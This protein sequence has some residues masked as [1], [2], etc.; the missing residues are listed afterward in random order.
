MI[1]QRRLISALGATACLAAAALGTPA[2]AATTAWAPV[3]ASGPTNLPPLQSEIQ[4]LGVDADGGAFK[5][6]FYA[7][8]GRG[9]V[10]AG[11]KTVF[12][13]T[14]TSGNFAVG[15]P[16]AGQGIAAGTTIA[17]V[18]AG[19][20]T[21][22]AN[23]TASSPGSVDLSAG[24]AEA[25]PTIP[26]NAPAATVEAVLDGLPLIAAGGGSVSVLGGPGDENST[27]PY[28]IDFD[29]G[30]L[31]N[32]NVAQLGADSSALEGSNK[33]AFVATTVPGGAGTTDVYVYVQ[34]VGSAES[35]GTTTVAIALP[36]GIVATAT[37]SGEGSWSCGPSGPGQFSCASTG[38]PGPAGPGLPIKKPIT[39]PVTAEPGASG[40]K[41]IHVSVSGGGAAGTAG[42]NMPL[43]ISP[44]PAPP[45]IQSFTAGAYNEDGVLDSRAGAHPF[46]A[47][48]AIF[49]NSKRTLTG[50]V[51]P[52][53]EPKD[54]FVD[55]PPGF[56]GNPIAVPA[57]P[58]ATAY[59]ECPTDS[60]V[61]VV[62]PIIE[63]LHG[64]LG[65]EIEPVVNA[66]APFGYPAKFRFQAGGFGAAV[67]PVNVLA[68]LRSDED[69]GITAGS[70]NTVQ[71][72]PVFGTFFSFWG[73]PAGSSHDNQRCFVIEAGCTASSTAADTAFAT[74]A[75]NCAEEALSPPVTT[76]RI[77]TW[78]S[79]SEIF[80]RSVT[81][82]PVAGCN[83]LHFESHF[84]FQPSEPA[85]ADSPAAFTTNL[86]VPAE[87]LTNPGKL[88]T[89]EQK[90]TVVRFPRGV[91]LNPSAAD[92][93]A[94]C[95]ERQ[96][97]LKGTNFAMPNPVRFNKA[98]NACPDASKIGVVE[99]KTAL[100]ASTLHGAL[101]LAAQG[102]GNPFGS[103]FAVYLVI[104]DPRTGIFIKLPGKAD[105]DSQTGQMT[106]TFDDLPQLPF[107]SLKLSF[108]GGSRAPFA[109]PT[110]CGKYLTTTLN[111]P[112]SAPE[113]GP[114]FE[115][116]DEFEVG[117]GPNGSVCANAPGGRPFGLGFTAEST[118]PIA[119]AH[120]P[121]A[122]Q[123]TRPDGAQ[124]LDT[125]DIS[126]PTGFS[127]VLKGVPYCSEAQI[128]V[129]QHS[130][131]AAEQASSACPAASRIGVTNT[132]AGSGPNPF[133][134]KGKLFLAGPYKG[135][136]LSAVAITPAVAGPFDLGNVVVRSALFV[137]PA[138]ARVSAKTDPIPRFVRGVALRI[139]D[140]RIDLDR[141]DWALNPTSCDVKS[142]D[143]TAHG[144]S[145]AV[146][147]LSNRFQVAGCENLA[148]K[149]K[150]RAK[151]NGG[152][153]RND[154]P[155]LRAELTY[156]PGSGYANTRYV[157][158]ALPHSE[159]LDQAHI[160]T[161]CTRP[162][163]AA[164][165][166]PAGSIYGHAK[167]I[168]PLLDQPLS[169]PVY[170][171]SSANKLPDLVIALKGPPSQPIEVDL[172]GRIDSVHGGIRTTFEATPDAP[173]SKFV[174][175]M[176]GGH[177]GLLVNS[178]N[179]CS[180]RAARMT[181]RLVAHNNKR[182]D[183]FPKLRDD[184]GKKHRKRHG[185]HHR[186]LAG[187][188]RIEF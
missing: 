38:F 125:L 113:S 90:T 115:T 56:L 75:T 11:S 188:G 35:S 99:V 43:T 108:K 32:A 24:P 10:F 28:F 45:G 159:F 110:T 116:E 186:V 22:S 173:V 111:T 164:H 182:A 4:R 184:C 41:E 158:V 104:E 29:G 70:P 117:S 89:P 147:D 144:D 17:A 127:A 121:F 119:G 73:A 82:P 166:C 148:F 126:T 98:P 84:S 172:D 133:Y 181:V 51:A 66:E 12:N 40:T 85:G 87:G 132:G 26:Y 100:L 102:D 176:Q 114:P 53:G 30:P 42:Y 168:T 80:R 59:S 136:P 135:A 61:G 60:I 137:D 76:L 103:L 131:G 156:P 165:T 63:T 145:G 3:A 77:N 169:G 185:P 101:Y 178:R 154:H 13:V 187:W 128:A 67:L 25:T 18:G 31:A 123:I 157:Q 27:H 55:L 183:Q 96:I 142:V 2:M 72:E 153:H 130:T 143:V 124:E 118:S 94:A 151:L 160:N 78:Q 1:A 74:Q 16:I 21:L 58:E 120:S 155:S 112:W 33:S 167:A 162:Q 49:V 107:T 174:L 175:T 149:P 134:A 95:S 161:V 54:I 105:P 71:I 146:S 171:R 88:T 6:I 152:T 64:G 47:N 19:T 140:V 93:L 83:Q 14:T 44:V 23:A 34:N 91:V 36:V 15:Q 69:Y 138:T 68:E 170:L 122:L 81:T 20:L 79:P 57:C 141:K 139:R 9:E 97:G 163:F 50:E 129:A 39:V 109:T 86:T 52:S 150:L 37:P 177:R 106:A 62:K 65:S 48:T 5:L 8:G 92:G 46:S 180:G 7:T 179:L